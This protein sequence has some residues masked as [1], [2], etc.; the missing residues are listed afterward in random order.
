MPRVY[1]AEGTLSLSV[2][3]LLRA[4]IRTAVAYLDRVLVG[5][6]YSVR[7]PP[8][9]LDAVDRDHFQRDQVL[10]NRTLYPLI[11]R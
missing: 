3:E 6:A 4:P 2:V 7:Y 9:M 8:D 5:Q 1:R 11:D 10:A